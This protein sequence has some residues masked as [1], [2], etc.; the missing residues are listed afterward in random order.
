MSNP[1]IHLLIKIARNDVNGVGLDKFC[2]G[3]QDV[4]GL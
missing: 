3:T 4:I 1:G 2:D